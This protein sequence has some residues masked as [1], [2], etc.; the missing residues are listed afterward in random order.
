MNIEIHVCD[1][2]IYILEIFPENNIHGDL[3]MIILLIELLF[4]S[5]GD[6]IYISVIINMKMILINDIDNS[7]C[8]INI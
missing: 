1:Y 4:I 8:C 5:A 6:Y 2:L 3:Q 7:I